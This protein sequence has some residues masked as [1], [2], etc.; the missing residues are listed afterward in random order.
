[1]AYLLNVTIVWTVLLLCFELLYKHNGRF[2]ANR[3]YLLGS[4]TLGFVL[5]FFTIPASFISQPVAAQVVHNMATVATAMPVQDVTNSTAVPTVTPPAA[6]TWQPDVN[7][8][9]MVLYSIGVLLLLLKAII[10]VS[11]IVALLRQSKTRTLYGHRVQITGKAHAP[12]SFMNRIFLPG[13][14]GYTS[15]E[16]Q[17]I[18]GH[19]H[20]HNRRKHWVDLWLMQLVCMLCWFHPLVWRYR[21]LLKLQHEYEADRAAS[22]DDRYEYG[23]FLL[24]LTLLKGAPSI[25]HS[26]HFSPIKNRINMLTTKRLKYGNNRYLLLIPA[27]LG[28]S[29]LVANTADKSNI[30]LRAD[31]SSFQGSTL[32]WRQTD[33]MFYDRATGELQLHH[34]SSD[35]RQII[36]QIN[37]EPV[38]QNEYLSSPAGWGNN[39]MSYT[40]YLRREFKGLMENTTDSLTDL[41]VMNVLVGKDGKV[42]YYDLRYPR[43]N[44]Q[45]DEQRKTWDPVYN[46]DARFNK[47]V[48][49]L[50][51][52]MPRWKPAYRYGQPVNSFVTFSSGC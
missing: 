6:N 50:I 35:P 16:L 13:I 1:M 11:K 45:H 28:C 31:Q 51:N 22:G 27:L 42:L 41:M 34:P 52:E 14:E 47:I 5:P 10:E 39:E 12:F 15:E 29:L 36:T 38:Y 44:Y 23:H 20:E 30:N 8:I 26:F 46:P 48:D 40:A 19:E 18:M 24:Q 3:I 32:T 7:F 43:P 2:T 9:L 37:N 4:I 25:A 49:K 21:Y 33:T 17:Y